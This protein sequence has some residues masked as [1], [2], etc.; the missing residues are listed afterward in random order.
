MESYTVETSGSGLGFPLFLQDPSTPTVWHP[1][2]GYGDQNR[3]GNAILVLGLQVNFSLKISTGAG[4]DLQPTRIMIV[5]QAAANGLPITA[6][7]QQPQG[8]TYSGITTAFVLGLPNPDYESINNIIYDEVFTPNRET[9]TDE[10]TAVRTLSFPLEE[11][12]MYPSVSGDAP[13]D[14]KYIMYAFTAGTAGVIHGMANKIFTDDIH[15]GHRPQAAPRLSFPAQM[16]TREMTGHPLTTA[17]R[18]ALLAAYTPNYLSQLELEHKQMRYNPIMQDEREED[19][20]YWN[21]D[22]N[23]IEDGDG[24]W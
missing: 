18:S 10:W 1:T 22:G 16:T 3:V 23:L 24:A 20:E 5:R 4:S 17:E 14:F 8:T 15:F 7:L 2:I 21:L 6:L 9:S 13:L 12:Q 11:I 19:E